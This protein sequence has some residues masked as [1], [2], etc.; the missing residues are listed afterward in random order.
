[1]ND[2]SFLRRVDLGDLDAFVVEEDLHLIEQELVRIRIRNVEPEVVNEL[3]FVSS[4]TRP[5]SLYRSP[6]RSFD[7]A[8]SGSG[9]RQAA[10]F[11]DHTART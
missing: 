2:L 8:R 7:R 6:L 5:S 9:P 11:S 10:H 1:M 4:A 3:F